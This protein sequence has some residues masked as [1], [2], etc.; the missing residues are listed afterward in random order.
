MRI[1]VRSGKMPDLRRWCVS[2]HIALRWS[3][4]IRRITLYRHIAPLERKYPCCPVG[5]MGRASYTQSVGRDSYL[6]R[7]MSILENR[8]TI[9]QPQGLPLRQSEIV[10]RLGCALLLHHFLRFLEFF[11]GECSP[12][13]QFLVTEVWFLPIVVREF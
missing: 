2:I 8:P 11:F 4:R 10:V 13:L 12:F 7:R 6:D 5:V 1:V 9:G 3:A